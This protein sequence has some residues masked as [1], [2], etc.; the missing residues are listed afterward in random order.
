MAEV[1]IKV[2]IDGKESISTIDELNKSLDQFKKNTDGL[3]EGSKEVEDFNK[4][5]EDLQKT[6]SDGLALDLDTDQ[7]NSRL[8]EVSTDLSNLTN[9]KFDIKVDVPE[10]TIN[11]VAGLRKEYQRLTAELENTDPQSAKYKQLES[12]L[13]DVAIR[14]ADAKNRIDEFNEGIKV[15]TGSPIEQFRNSLALTKEGLLNL[16]FGKVGTGLS[17]LGGAAKATIGP[18]NL[19]KAALISTGVGAL[20]VGLGLLIANFEELEQAIFGVSS[21]DKKNLQLAEDRVSLEKEKLDSI[22]R[23]ENSLK[24]QGKS[25]QEILEL[26]I[27]QTNETINATKA[28]LEQQKILTKL[29]IEN[30]K[31]N[32]EILQGIIETTRK[33][34]EDII[35]AIDTLVQF[36]DKDAPSLLE[37]Y[38]KSSKEA[39]GFFDPEE[40]KKEGEETEAELQKTIETLTNQRDGYRISVNNINKQ[41]TE[42]RLKE[43]EKYRTELEKLNDKYLTTESERI[44]KQYDAEL[45]KIKEVGEEEVKLR[46]AIIA[47]RDEELK[48]L[49]FAAKDKA[50]KD[51]IELRKLRAQNL[52]EI[53]KIELDSLQLETDI[54]LRNT[55]LT[56]TERN[57]IIED[58]A[59]KRAEINQKFLD[60]ETKKVE[61]EVNKQADII[62]AQR[63]DIIGERVEVGLF[64]TLDKLKE[65][66]QKEKDL[67]KKQFDDLKAINDQIIND[68]N[69]SDEDKE[70]ARQNNLK[71]Q[72]D[73]NDK[74]YEIDEEGSIAR[75]ELVTEEIQKRAGQINEALNIVASLSNA[76]LDSEKERL[77][78]VAAL[79]DADFER[80][81]AGIEEAN[82]SDEERT[83]KLK[84]LDAIQLDAKNK[85]EAQKIALEKKAIKREALF[86]LASISLSAAESIAAAVKANKTAPDPITFAL[87][88]A[89]NLA[90]VFIAIKKARDAFKDANKAAS[91]LGGSA[92]GDVPLPS[93]PSGAG[94][95]AQQFTPTGFQPT[96]VNPAQGGGAGAQ[97]QPTQ[98]QQFVS[99]VEIERVRNSVNVIETQ[100]TISGGG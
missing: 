2:N 6:L 40:T 92:G 64:G 5:I 93:A 18:L 71:L 100:N 49:D 91:S 88:I 83:K 20:V 54:K 21:E 22:S 43:E 98:P 90:A 12:Q 30:T 73:Y 3:E 37:K 34:V 38:R 28:Q 68:E 39:F 10:K 47:R 7:L 15:R 89:A 59:K 65:N 32:R 33:P 75:T 94:G 50:A 62:K 8:T 11:S 46:A 35:G 97:D 23:Q 67:A 61:E 52:D 1:K 45:S 42:E 4:S 56:E 82:L 26:K 58:A 70:A 13:K 69:R 66:F 86:A 17:G 87:G 53:R 36:F 96:G 81:R 27:N 55:K 16:D 29:Q 48:N 80:R 95:G 57:I 79:Q 25:E 99:V 84:E 60:E 76:Q 41:S 77:D 24:L 51:A 44:T 74:L 72:K 63:E 14:S 85:L 9:Q 31:R 19:F 78:E